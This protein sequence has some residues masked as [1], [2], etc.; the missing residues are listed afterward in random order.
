MNRKVLNDDRHYFKRKTKMKVIGYTAKG[1]YPSL[2]KKI[3]EESVNKFL[4]EDTREILMKA[5]P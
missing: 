2:N 1:F 5:K 3:E 4:F